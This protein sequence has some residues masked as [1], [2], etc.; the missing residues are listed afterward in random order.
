MLICI[1]AISAV[2]AE[3]T[4]NNLSYNNN[5]ISADMSIT[6]DDEWELYHFSN[7][8]LNM[9]NENGNF[10]KDNNY[11][12]DENQ[13]VGVVAPGNTFYLDYIDRYGNNKYIY[14]GFDSNLNIWMEQNSNINSELKGHIP[15]SVSGFYNGHLIT[16]KFNPDNYMGF[17]L[18]SAYRVELDAFNIPAGG[19]TSYIDG[20]NHFSPTLKY[21]YL[22]SLNVDESIPLNFTDYNI[23]RPDSIQLDPNYNYNNHNGKGTFIHSL[24]SDIDSDVIKPYPLIYLS[25]FQYKTSVTFKAKI[26]S[27][28]G[29]IVRIT[30]NSVSGYFTFRINNKTQIDY[31]KNNMG[32]TTFDYLNPGKYTVE[33]TYSGDNSLRGC[34]FNFSF[35]VDEYKINM[36]SNSVNKYYGGSEKLI[37]DVSDEYESNLDGT[38]VKVLIKE[39]VENN[40]G[41]VYINGVLIKWDNTVTYGNKLINYDYQFIKFI[42]SSNQVAIDLDLNP[43]TYDVII[44]CWNT[45]YSTKVTVKSTIDF[46]YISDVRLYDLNGK[47]LYYEKVKVIIDNNE[48]DCFTDSGGYIDFDLTPGTHEIEIVNPITHEKKDTLLTRIVDTNIL[49]NV[50]KELGMVILTANVNPKPTKGNISFMVSGWDYNKT[51]IVP[52]K[53]GKSTIS[54]S[55]LKSEEENYRIPTYD[56]TAKYNGCEYYKPSSSKTTFRP[57]TGS[58]IISAPNITCYYGSS[59]KFG[60]TLK[61]NYSIEIKDGLVKLDIVKTTR[62]FESIRKI[63]QATTDKNGYVLFDLG[64]DFAIKTHNLKI[65]YGSWEVSSNI[66]I[67]PS[68]ETCGN[69]KGAYQY[70]FFNAT[71]YGNNGKPLN[72]QEVEYKISQKS[73]STKTKTE[74]GSTITD[75]NGNVH[76]KIYPSCYEISIYNP[77]TKEYKRNNIDIITNDSSIEKRID[78]QGS[79]DSSQWDFAKPGQIIS[80]RISG[81]AYNLYRNRYP[82][83]L[84]NDYMKVLICNNSIRCKVIDGCIKFRLPDVPQLNE[85]SVVYDG[86]AYEISDE[87]CITFHPY[88]Y[89]VHICHNTTI[90]KSNNNVELK[91]WDFI[92]CKGFYKYLLYVDDEYY[93]YNWR[94]WDSD[95]IYFY[96]NN[97]SPGWHDILLKIDDNYFYGNSSFSIYIDSFNPNNDTSSSNNQNIENVEDDKVVNTFLSGKNV[98]MYYKNG[99][100]SVTLTDEKGYLLFNQKIIFNLNGLEYSRTTDHAGVASLNINL[101]SGTHYISAVFGGSNDYSKSNI[102]NNTIKIIPTIV[103][104]DFSKIYKNGTQYYGTFVDSMGNLL[105][106]TDVKFNINGVYY[107]RTTNDKGVARMN[108]NLNPGTYI[109]TATNPSNGENIATKIKVLPLIITQDLTKYYKNASKLTF[110][111]LDNQGKPVGAGVSATIN[112]NGVFYT[113][114]TDANGYVNMNINLSPGTY[115]ATIEY[116]GLMMSCNVKVL[117]ILSAKDVYMKFKDGSKFEVKLVNGQGRPFAG[118]KITFN[119]NGVFYERIT[120]SNGIARLNI[121]LMAGEYIITSMYENGAAL[122]NKVT[123]SS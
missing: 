44:Q 56:V 118:Q 91:V 80:V 92:N 10:L 49:L 11:E 89:N 55:N 96:L 111:L 20:I 108:I 45:I 114:A 71:L 13:Y 9:S 62:N 58:V 65:Q 112:I 53:D 73:E 42:N 41:Q 99:K 33:V 26:N 109:L 116:N 113:R 105:K 24:Y 81:Y 72:N 34:S 106:N 19:D 4:D 122:S 85:F 52:I 38:S 54:L 25:F 8:E 39:H 35:D 18:D 84:N 90:N 87:S 119:I 21:D 29:N 103:S 5:Q 37:I 32:K 48:Y 97:L 69:L 70:T 12:L 68:I 47:G 95:F 74:S 120:D 14:C 101:N 121:N 15:N 28:I 86:T 3:E 107:T 36:S 94:D 102:V 7:D 17:R 40:G 100:Y 76:I 2:S 64:S 75:E 83:D 82:V 123:I 66:T 43:G 60:A 61:N 23:Y 51:Y 67:V 27:T 31:V 117:H 79:C 77:I 22:E 78:L 63:F 98:E 104:K 6:Y 59:V 16:Y 110:R 115:I 88:S 57:N 50:K 30:P 1:F 46:N 93:S